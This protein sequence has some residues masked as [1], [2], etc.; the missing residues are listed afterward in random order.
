MKSP[1]ISQSIQMK[2]KNIHYLE[3]G[4]PDAPSVLLLH[5]ASFRAK[6]WEEIGTIKQLTNQNYRVVAVDLPGYGTSATISDEPVQFLVKLTDN[7]QLH[8][9]VIVSPSMSGRYS[10]PFI[11][12]HHESVRGFVAVAPVGIL[13]MA[14]KLEGIQIPTLAIWGSNDQIVPPSQADILIQTMPN[15][16]K[17]IL[18]NAGH[19]CYLKAPNKFHE[20]LIQFLKSLK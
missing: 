11:I 1:I 17:A 12:Q 14:E 20:N 9:T 10:L 18:K 4:Q 13:K 2:N 5:G 7:L 3:A 16:Q 8:N 15:C 19:A 6:T